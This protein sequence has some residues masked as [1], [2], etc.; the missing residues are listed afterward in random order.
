MLL[1]LDSDHFFMGV[2]PKLK[3]VMQFAEKNLP[4]YD[5][6]LTLRDVWELQTFIE[7]GD[8]KVKPI[9]LTKETVLLYCGAAECSIVERIRGN[10]IL[11]NFLR[12]NP[13]FS[14]VIGLWTLTYHKIFSGY[15]VTT[16]N[17]PIMFVA[18]SNR[19]WSLVSA[20][21]WAMRDAGCPVGRS[22]LEDEN[23]LF[24][25]DTISQFLRDWRNELTF[26][27]LSV[28]EGKD[29]REDFLLRLKK[30]IH[31]QKQNWFH[32]RG[33]LILVGSEGQQDPGFDT[34]KWIWE[35]EV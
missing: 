6:E 30:T 13:M 3:R 24:C 16:P 8:L 11:E 14:V 1:N 7:D 25:P 29:D 5:C 19:V 28:V 17:K 4:V 31:F 10:E 34:N 12:K 9:S 20:V 2:D 21:Y 18:Q 23:E 26:L 32:T 35:F 22:P 15:N 27:D 33:P